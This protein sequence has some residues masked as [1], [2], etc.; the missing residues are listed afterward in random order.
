MSETDMIEKVFQG[1]HEDDEVRIKS[2]HGCR[3]RRARL[4]DVHIL[5]GE[6]PRLRTWQL[7]ELIIGER[8]L[9]AYKSTNATR[10]PLRLLDDSGSV[11]GLLTMVDEIL[12]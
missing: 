9:H 12:F 2:R 6:N 4:S 8:L 11:P 10:Y 5:Q 1:L 3:S 7:L